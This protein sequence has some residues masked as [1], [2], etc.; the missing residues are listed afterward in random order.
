MSE[1]DG[2]KAWVGR[3][4]TSSGLLADELADRFLATLDLERDMTELP[5]GIHWCVGLESAATGKLGPDGHPP[6]GDFLPPVPYPRRMWAGGAMQIFGPLLR[7]QTV[8]RRS[9]IAAVE[10]KSG[11][12][13]N[14]CFV[15][16]QH[17]ILADGKLVIEERQDIVYREAGPAGASLPIL[18]ADEARS[19]TPTPPLL[20]RYSAMTFNA[21]RIHYDLSYAQREE[22]YPGLVI[23]GP[24][25]ATLLADH[26]ARQLSRPLRRFS[27]RGQAPAF[28]TAALT[29]RVQP[30]GDGAKVWSEQYGKPCMIAEAA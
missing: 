24:L 4:T 21:H 25:Q 17:G 1:L 10:P 3:E 16:V 14:L 11:K 29:L 23:H 19:L 6:K 13:G 18:P 2:L 26:A 9:R 27:F 22:N 8:E 15:T 28:D 30:E 20:F 7:G 12:S 5:L